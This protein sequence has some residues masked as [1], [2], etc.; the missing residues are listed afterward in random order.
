MVI[1]AWTHLQAYHIDQRLVSDVDL[2]QDLC[3]RHPGNEQVE[4]HKQ[5]EDWGQPASGNRRRW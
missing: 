3:D 2:T 5:R 1:P 4:R